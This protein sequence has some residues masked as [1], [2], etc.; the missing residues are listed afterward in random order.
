MSQTVAGEEVSISLSWEPQL[1]VRGGICPK[2]ERGRRW[3]GR[4]TRRPF[5]ASRS[6]P[7][8]SLRTEIA[9]GKNQ[10]TWTTQK[11]LTCLRWPGTDCPRENNRKEEMET[12][13]GKRPRFACGTQSCPARAPQA[14]IPRK[15]FSLRFSVWER[16]R[17]RCHQCQSWGFLSFWMRWHDTETEHPGTWEQKKRDKHRACALW[18]VCSHLKAQG[19]G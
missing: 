9:W 14:P 13:E 8:Q 15:V 19:K 6:W 12:K 11:R 5:Q 16:T 18:R 1:W 2:E 7:T 4:E 10:G 17:Q 3:G